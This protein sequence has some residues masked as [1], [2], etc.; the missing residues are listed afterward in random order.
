[1][2]FKAKEKLQLTDFSLSLHIIGRLLLYMNQKYVI[3]YVNDGSIFLV[4]CN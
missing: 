3:L 2:N 4:T 1:M